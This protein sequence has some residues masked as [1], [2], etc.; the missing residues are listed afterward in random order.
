V[1]IGTPHFSRHSSPRILKAL[2]A[3]QSSPESERDAAIVEAE[4]EDTA[5]ADRK[6]HK[7]IAILAL[8]AGVDIAL[9]YFFWNY[10]TRKTMA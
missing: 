7:A 3:T 8:I 10:G 9:I 2:A 4:R 6:L 5:D 1:L